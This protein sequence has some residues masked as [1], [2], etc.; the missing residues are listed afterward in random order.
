MSE[1]SGTQQA[2]VGKKRPVSIISHVSPSYHAGAAK[3]IFHVLL[4][5]VGC[6][7][8]GSQDSNT[9][10]WSGGSASYRYIGPQQLVLCPVSTSLTLYWQMVISWPAS[11][12][13]LVC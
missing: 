12:H 4:V 10:H 7:T 8:S 6:V 1:K 11:L 9:C 13:I 2:A 3:A 5:C